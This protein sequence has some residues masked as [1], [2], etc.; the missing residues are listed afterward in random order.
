MHTAAQTTEHTDA[1]E[2]AEAA[3][4]QKSNSSKSA[5][6]GFVGEKELDAAIGDSDDQVAEKTSEEDDTLEKAEATKEKK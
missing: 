3:K 4:E 6:E 1:L 2:K 5:T